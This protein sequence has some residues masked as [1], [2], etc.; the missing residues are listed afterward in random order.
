ME[1]MPEKQ[2]MLGM[3][4][5]AK[6]RVERNTLFLPLSAPPVSLWDLPLAESSG[7]LQSS[8]GN[9]VSCYTEQSKRR[10]EN[11]SERRKTNDC[12]YFLAKKPPNKLQIPQSSYMLWILL[13]PFAGPLCHCPHTLTLKAANVG[14]P[15]T[16]PA[17]SVPFLTQYPQP[18]RHSFPAIV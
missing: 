18:R 8:L 15:A 4:P 11:R 14:T 10:A 17:T 2:P 7:Q 5:K 16:M 13:C 1:K 12:T 6:K 9:V 3:P